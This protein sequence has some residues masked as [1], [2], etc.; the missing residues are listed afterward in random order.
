L[1]FRVSARTILH[2]GSELISSDGI[3][4]YEL[5]KNA[6]DAQSPEIRV[7]VVYRLEFDAYDQILRALGERR[8]VPGWDVEVLRRS[9]LVDD[10]DD[11]R[12]WRTHRE[13][14]IDAL[15]PG[16][17]EVDSVRSALRNARNRR[18]FL[19]ALRGANY[20][21]FDDDGEGMSERVLADVYLTIGT[22]F[23]AEQKRRR[24][25]RRTRAPRPT[26]QRDVILG[27]K[28]LGRLSAMRLGDRMSVIT[29]EADESHWNELEIDWNDFADAADS[30]LSAV[31]VAPEEGTEKVPEQSGTIIK[32]SALR[33][34]WSREKLEQMAIDHFSKLVDPFDSSAELPLR[35]TFNGDAVPIPTFASFLLDQ[36]HGH[37]RIEYRISRTGEP[38]LRGRMEYRLRNRRNTLTLNGLDLQTITDCDR[39]VLQRVGRFD[40]ELYWF[41]RRILTKIEG[42]GSLAVV[43]R[44]LAAWAGGVSLYRDGYRVNPYGGPYD[45][46]LDLDRD[47]FSTSG[48]K[49]NRGQIIGRASITQDENP[50]L[51]DQTNREGLKDSPETQA[52]VGVLAAAV[53]QYR[54]YIVEIDRDER[55][56]R[57]VTA[58]DALQRFREED[59]RL[60]GLIPEIDA[61]LAS[62]PQGRSLARRMAATLV[63]LRDAASLVQQI[64]GAQE[65]ERGRVIHLASIGLMIEIL[66]HELYRSVANGLKTIAQ[67]R[68]A[69]DP[70]S[71]STSLRVLDAQLRSLQKRLKVLDPL[72]V[73][74]RQTRETFELTAW[75]EDI[76]SG[77][78]Q[79]N[80][81]SRI[82]ISTAVRPRGSTLEVRAVSGMFVQVLENLLSNSLFWIGQ[83]HRYD[84]RAG[85]AT[86]EADPI[87]NIRV[88]VDTAARRILVTDS[89]PGIP[90]DRRDIVFEPFFST[91]PQKQGRGLGLYIAREIAE[92]HGGTLSLGDADEDGQIHTVIFELGEGGGE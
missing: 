15:V 57:R 80:G 9:A 55:R 4:F 61:A 41:N 18:S 73:N 85:L 39:D 38:R 72:S 87:G 83:K 62:S 49:L 31:P 1:N 7:D 10:R 21:H 43:R 32:I 22:G 26:G 92:Y 65:E 70:A 17:P 68:G 2:L 8:D 40:M 86:A 25:Q 28:G 54:L 20:I 24:L 66:A 29:G 64:A 34:A 78:A 84:V 67:A 48:F 53:E 44:I 13:A 63:E 81:S 45:D 19:E 37:F 33:S 90:E 60:A 51:V 16:S 27:E 14:A 5:I 91:R 59:D 71:T 76:V 82:R 12:N 58:A 11:P 3:A 77:F 74:A 23:R 36:A 56:A 35:L 89:G 69:R 42:V 46:W 52:F 47:A 30:D 79:R 6:I 88:T 75:V 50:Y